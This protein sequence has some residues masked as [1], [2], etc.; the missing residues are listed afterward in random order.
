MSRGR[1][2]YR[3]GS[4]ARAPAADGPAAEGVGPSVEGAVAAAQALA[5]GTRLR[6]LML[7]GEGEAVVAELVT[8]LMVPQPNVSHHLAILRGLGAVEARRDGRSIVYRLLVPPPAPGFVR[9]SAGGATV[10]IT[11]SRG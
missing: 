5:D 1:I 7:L 9:V 10:T 4:A 6:L 3:P 11:P 8:R 2:P